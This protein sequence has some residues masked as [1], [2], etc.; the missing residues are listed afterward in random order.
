MSHNR[1]RAG[2]ASGHAVRSILHRADSYSNWN[3]EIDRRHA[4]R[5][6]LLIRAAKLT[7]DDAEFLCVVRDASEA[8]VSVRLFHP[9]P[10]GAVLTLEMP[11]GDRYPLQRVWEDDDSAGFRFC[12]PVELDRIIEGPS[13]YPRRPVRVRIELPCFL[14]LGSRRVRAMIG[15]LSQQGALIRTQEYLSLVQRIRVEVDGMPEIAAKVCWRQHDC[16]GLSFEGTFQFAELAA[17]A[18]DLQRERTRPRGSA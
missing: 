18:F 9:L 14:L 10:P 1:Q 4:P 5:F 6:T 8:G 12:E 16:Y 2:L 3:G 17:L 15:N 11:N 7:S 13:R